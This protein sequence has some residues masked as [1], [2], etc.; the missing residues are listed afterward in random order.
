MMH[1]LVVMFSLQLFIIIVI[2]HWTITDSQRRWRPDR[3]GT[4]RNKWQITG[5]FIMLNVLHINKGVCV[6]V[7]VCARVRV[8]RSTEITLH[9][10]TNIFKQI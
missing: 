8:F 4:P 2:I 10:K 7:C 3:R 5:L 9:M 6:C 1:A